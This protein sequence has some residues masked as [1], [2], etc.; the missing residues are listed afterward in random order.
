VHK[1]NISHGVFAVH[2][3]VHREKFLIIKPTRCTHFSNLFLEWKSTCFGQFFCPSSGDFHCKHSKGLG[4][5][6]L[7]T[8][9][10]SCQQNY[11][12]YCCVYSEKIL[13]M[14]RGTLRIM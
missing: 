6:L 10:R 9:A 14:D 13:M 11:T 1:K 5:R 12:T 2:V 4:H 8:A 7:R 3:T